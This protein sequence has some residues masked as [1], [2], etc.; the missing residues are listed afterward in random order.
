MSVEKR[1]IDARGAPGVIT[2]SIMRPMVMGDLEQVLVIEQN[3]FP[4]PWST[5][6]FKREMELDFS[7]FF[8]LE[9]DR[10]I[11]GYIN[12]WLSVGE[13]HIMS[14]AVKEEYRK[15]GIGSYILKYSMSTARRLGGEYVY[16]EARI[17]NSAALAL[18]R[19]SGFELIGIRRGYYTDTK[20]DAL[21]LAREL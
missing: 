13:V 5:T 20:E 10:E 7:Y 18:Y 1:E 12:F 2:G 16:L 3:S 21:I 4:T 14:I 11:I 9:L 19:K 15:R 6:L 17:T 8:V